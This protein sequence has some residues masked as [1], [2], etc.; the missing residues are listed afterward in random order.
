MQNRGY[1]PFCHDLLK[2]IHPYDGCRIDTV[3][4]G[5][6]EPR[7]CPKMCNTQCLG[8]PRRTTGPNNDRVDTLSG[9][10]SFGCCYASLIALM[11]LL[12]IK[13]YTYELATISPWKT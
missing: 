11:V 7:V 10:Y 9:Q 3:E 6:I 5:K 8:K 13:K 4:H 2:R 1:L 12:R